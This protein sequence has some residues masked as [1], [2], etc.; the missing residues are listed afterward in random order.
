MSEFFDCATFFWTAVIAF[1]IHQVLAQGKGR[2]VERYEIYYHLVAW[3]APPPRASG[4]GRRCSRVLCCF[5]RLSGVPAVFL[6][7]AIVADAFGDAGNWCWI[8]AEHQG[9][10]FALYYIPLICVF[11]WNGVRVR[12]GRCRC[13]CVVPRTHASFALR[14]RRYS[15]GYRSR[16]GA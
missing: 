9:L 8:T 3:G 12:A 2:T 6:I 14:C 7:I 5:V 16:S 13:R 1:N 15:T 4:R 10:R 11:I